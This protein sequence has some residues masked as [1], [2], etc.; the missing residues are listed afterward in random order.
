MRSTSIFEDR[1]AEEVPAIPGRTTRP[2]IPDDEANVLD[3]RA[4]AIVAQVEASTGS[5]EMELFDSVSAVGVE[6]QRRGGHELES[7][8]IRVGEMLGSEAVASR[9]TKELINLRIELGKISP[10]GKSSTRARFLGALPFGNSAL[11]QLERIAVRYETVSKQIVTVERRLAEGRAMLRSDNEQLRQLY[12]DVEQQQT[13]ILRNIYLGNRLIT[14]LEELIARVTDAAKRER[15]QRLLFDVTMR[16]QDMETMLE[17]HAQ[18]F[19]GIEL[20]RVNNSRLSQAV[21]RTLSLATST[22]MVGLALQ[23]ALS[24][25]RRVLDATRRTREFLGDLI[26]TNAAAIKQQATEIGDVYREPVVALEKLEQAHHD[27]EEAIDIAAKLEVDAIEQAKTNIGRLQ[28]MTE[29]LAQR[30]GSIPATDGS[31]SIEA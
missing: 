21:D 13:P 17:V 9:V 29:R 16:V 10:K 7:L 23:A 5:K 18:F 30:A 2:S 15:L 4:A 26:V 28:Q 25:Q 1:P 24:N 14:A 19:V 11:H 22:L 20:T 6:A 12:K 31:R 8:R 3:E 27:L